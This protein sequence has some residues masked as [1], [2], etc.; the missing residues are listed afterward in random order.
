MP[1][2]RMKIRIQWQW[3]VQ[4]LLR[5]TRCLWKQRSFPPKKWRPCKSLCL[6]TTYPST[7]QL[8]FRF[9]FPLQPGLCWHVSKTSEEPE[10]ETHPRPKSVAPNH[11]QDPFE[12]VECNLKERDSLIFVGVSE[13]SIRRNKKKNWHSYQCMW[14]WFMYCQPLRSPPQDLFDLLRQQFFVEDVDIFGHLHAIFVKH[15]RG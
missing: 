5:Q 10:L 7:S 9:T 15:Q 6:V 2:D 4:C 11:L 8:G 1:K 13:E 12:C 14:Y 3:Q